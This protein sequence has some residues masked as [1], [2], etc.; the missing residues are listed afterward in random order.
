MRNKDIIE[1]QILN[2]PILEGPTY[3]CICPAYWPCQFP[4]M[5]IK[6]TLPIKK[7]WKGPHKFMFTSSY[8]TSGIQ[9]IKEYCNTYVLQSWVALIKLIFY[10]GITRYLQ[11]VHYRSN[12][13]MSNIEKKNWEILLESS[14]FTPQIMSESNDNFRTVSTLRCL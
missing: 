11:M 7:S 10:I 12:L 8:Q 1:D 13:S 9:Q 2:I 14:T 4:V 6:F 3:S 5:L